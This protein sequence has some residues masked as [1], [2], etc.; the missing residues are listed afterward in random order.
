MPKTRF[1]LIGAGAVAQDYAQAFQR[2][3]HAELTA[4]ADVDLEAAV[5]LADQA[6]CKAFDSHHSLLRAREFDAALVCTPPVSHAPISI[7]LLRCGIH[8]LCEQPFSTDVASARRMLHVAERFGAT[9]TM[10]SK[11]RYVSDLIQTQSL[12]AGGL[13]GEVL[14]LENAFASRVK[15][16]GGW[17]ANPSVG[18][19]GVI[20]DSGTHSVDILRYLCGRI[21]AVAAFE[22]ARVQQLKVEDTAH[23]MARTER[24]VLASISLSWSCN[25]RSDSYL[26]IC[27]T[28][29]AITLGWS[30]SRYRHGS[31]ERWVSFGC[32]YNE[33]DALAAQVDN[34]CR[35]LQDGEPL[36][37]TADDSLASVEAIA[38]AYRSLRCD[39]WIAVDSSAPNGAP[40]S[41]LAPISAVR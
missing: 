9:L 22:G 25:D 30:R 32:G 18:G 38:G 20:I 6:G 27:G 29:G 13:L 36:T 37:I 7:D 2:S 15:M 23:V 31:S 3:E 21:T 8:V 40:C 41:D 12:I 28:E 11:F 1:A 35:W 34:F 5:R 39:R 17:H 10:A 24:G 26:Q 33:M 14:T 4:V 16:A 19:G